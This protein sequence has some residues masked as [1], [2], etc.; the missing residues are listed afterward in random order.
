LVLVNGAGV[1][2]LSVEV[3]NIEIPAV[4]RNLVAREWKKFLEAVRAHLPM[5]GAPDHTRLPA[6]AATSARR[7]PLAVAIKNNVKGTP[8][9]FQ[10]NKT[11]HHATHNLR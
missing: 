1:L 8:Q 10:D 6:F 3:K 9:L 5:I 4:G 7:P 2:S 11:T